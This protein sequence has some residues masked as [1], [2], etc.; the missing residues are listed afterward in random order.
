MDPGDMKP[1]GYM[2]GGHEGLYEKK[3][4]LRIQIRYESK[5]LEGPNKS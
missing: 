2:I 5:C 4:K 3:M 1:K